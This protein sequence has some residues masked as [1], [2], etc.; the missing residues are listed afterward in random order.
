MK[1]TGAPQ[2]SGMEQQKFEKLFS[3]HH[4]MVYRAALH[5][6]W[7]RWTFPAFSRRGG[8]AIKKRSRSFIGADGAV[9]KF[10]KN[11]VRFAV[12]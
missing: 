5:N 2:Q 8:C 4:G 6:K 10:K 9:S 3:E 1:M 11:K 7:L 12:S